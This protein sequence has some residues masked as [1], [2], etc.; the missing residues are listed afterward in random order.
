MNDISCNHYGIG[1][2]I[3]YQKSFEYRKR[4]VDL[5]NI[6][7]KY[8]DGID[9]DY[10][11]PFEYYKKSAKIGSKAAMNNVARCYRYKGRYSE[12]K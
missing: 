12:S 4:S 2:E 3:N 7:I 9:Q 1:A 11:K 10:N 6:E 5:N 8:G